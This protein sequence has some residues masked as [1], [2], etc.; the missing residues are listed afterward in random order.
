MVRQGVEVVHALQAV[1]AGGHKA[2]QDLLLVAVQRDAGDHRQA[3][4]ALRAQGHH[5][6]VVRHQQDQVLDDAGVVAGAQL[7]VVFEERQ[8]EALRAL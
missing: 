3:L 8:Q 6:R 5:P 1:P 7:V 4:Q 2:A